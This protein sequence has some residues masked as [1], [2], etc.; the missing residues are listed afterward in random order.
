MVIN[1]LKFILN[2]NPN[3]NYKM[4]IGD[5]VEIKVF[6]DGNQDFKNETNIYSFLNQL[7]PF[8]IYHKHLTYPQFIL[9]NN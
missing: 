3:I 1:K 2:I 9:I 8:L 7:E 6:D 5:F 4:N